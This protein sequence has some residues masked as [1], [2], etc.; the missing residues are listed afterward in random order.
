MMLRQ[1]VLC[2]RP[3]RLGLALHPTGGVL[4]GTLVGEDERGPARAARRGRAAIV[5]HGTV[6]HVRGVSRGA[7]YPQALERTPPEVF[8]RHRPC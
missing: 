2:A 6:G 8:L 3:P 7:C 5:R 1:V 4:G